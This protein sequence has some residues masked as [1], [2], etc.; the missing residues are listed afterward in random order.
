MRAVSVLI[1]LS[2]LAARASNWA[3]LGGTNLQNSVWARR[4]PQ[5]LT[6]RYNFAFTVMQQHVVEQIAT[7]AGA[8]S[9]E[10]RLRAQ[11][12]HARFYNNALSPLSSTRAQVA[13]GASPS[14]S[15]IPIYSA[16]SKFFIFGGEDRTKNVAADPSFGVDKDNLPLEPNAPKV[17]FTAPLTGAGSLRNDIFWTRGVKWHKYTDYRLKT[18]YSEPSQQIVSDLE[19]KEMPQWDGMAG[20][21]SWKVR[22]PPLNRKHCAE[23]R[24]TAW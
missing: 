12:A 3:Q 23:L 6:R 20:W 4:P 18:A 24:T 8:V 21:N 15:P 17:D 11:C 13:N 9:R 5:N 22:A 10:P 2:L 16:P 7:S 1:A 14:P 19:W